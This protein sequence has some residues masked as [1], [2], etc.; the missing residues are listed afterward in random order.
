MAFQGIQILI[1]LFALF[2]WSRAILRFKDGAIKWNELLFWSFLWGA[3]IVLTVNPAI[4][5]FFSKLVGIERGVDFF[6]YLSVMLLFYLIF[7]IYVK[8]D[9]MDQEITKVVR[10][11]ALKKRK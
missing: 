7:R 2:A 1:I 11:V 10:E 6:L 3:L 5:F 8:L 4:T 9:N